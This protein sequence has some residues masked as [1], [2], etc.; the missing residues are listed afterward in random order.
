M[1][2]LDRGLEVEGVEGVKEVLKS[3]QNKHATE[4]MNE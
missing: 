2:D 3:I 4:R 1:C